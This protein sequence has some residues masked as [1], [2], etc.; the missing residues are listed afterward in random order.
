MARAGNFPKLTQMREQVFYAEAVAQLARAR[1]SAVA[2]RER[3]TRLMGLYGDESASCCPS[4]CRICRQRPPEHERRGDGR[5]RQ[6]LDV[7]RRSARPKRSPS[8][9]GS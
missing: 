6:R 7:Q 3:L 4:A 8:R 2:E 9:S 1:Q 5:D